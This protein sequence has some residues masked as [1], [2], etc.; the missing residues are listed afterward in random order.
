MPHTSVHL[1]PFF[2]ICHHNTVQMY[3]LFL[4]ALLLQFKWVFSVFRFK[5]VL[6]EEKK[7]KTKIMNINNNNNNKKNIY[8]IIRGYNFWKLP[9]YN[10]YV[11]TYVH[12]CLSFPY[13][14]TPT[15]YRVILSPFSWFDYKIVPNI[16]RWLHFTQDVH[17]KTR[18]LQSLNR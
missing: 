10:P 9:Y 8:F 14:F 6:Y 7:N 2:L 15:H 3:F 4:T 12:V 11:F 5:Q 18:K 16:Q 13:T 1:R 17:I